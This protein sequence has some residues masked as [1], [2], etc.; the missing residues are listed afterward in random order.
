MNIFKYFRKSKDALPSNWQVRVT[1]D[2]VSTLQ[3]DEIFVFG[4]RNSG[5]HFD[6]ASAFALKHFGAVFGQ[7]EGRQGRSYAIPTIGGTI[8]LKDIR[9][10]VSRFT[11][12]AAEHPELHFLVTPI[13]CGGG[14]WSPYHIAPLFR[15]ASR[16]PNVS[17]PE[18]FWNELR[19]PWPGSLCKEASESLVSTIKHLYGAVLHRWMRLLPSRSLYR[20]LMGC[21]SWNKE[22]D[23]NEGFAW[24]KRFM[25]FYPK[26][27]WTRYLLNHK[28][29]RA[30]MVVDDNRKITIVHPKD[31]DWD[32]VSVLPN[33]VQKLIRKRMAIYDFCIYDYNDGVAKVMWQVSPD[34]S[35]YYQ[36]KYGNGPI[37]DE[38]D[39]RLYGHIDTQCRFVEKLHT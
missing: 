31:I 8:G 4:C 5:R 2:F 21:A 13:G 39:I 25:C 35:W 29:I 24:T 3:G 26:S 17:L 23:L 15:K 27:T 1:S 32:S 6:G 14:G 7:R 38:K 10:S 12:Y 37:T 33:K 18:D 16:L 34:G 28:T 22:L 9:D 36:D 20:V 30:Y 11:Q 19:K